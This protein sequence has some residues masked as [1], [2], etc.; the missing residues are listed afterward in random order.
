VHTHNLVRDANEFTLQDEIGPHNYRK[1]V[2]RGLP[3]AFV[4]IDPS[5]KKKSTTYE[6]IGKEVAAKFRGKIL[7]T[8]ADGVKFSGHAK[9]LGLSGDSPFGFAIEDPEG[10]H[11]IYPEDEELTEEALT[12]LCTSVA[13]GTAKPY[14]KSEPEP[15]DDQGPVV[16]LVGTNFQRIAIDSDKDVLIEFYAPWCGHCKSLAPIYEELATKL[17]D[18]KTM[19]IAKVDSTANDVPGFK[20]QSF[21]T[22]KFLPGGSKPNSIPFEG[23][24]TV[25]GF[26]S[27]LKEHATHKFDA[28]VSSTNETKIDEGDEEE[29]HD[30]L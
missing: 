10:R 23:D 21:P 5:Q 19:I 28:P 24:R 3:L 22:I 8:T 16:T 26:I 30:E 1:Y 9:N 15:V 12:T 13:D 6:T 17:K 2:S 18:V 7:F 4:F 29:E 27:F 11:F 20:I 25:D 14:L